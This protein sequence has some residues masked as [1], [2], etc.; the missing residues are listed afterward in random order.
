MKP[1]KL[2]QIIALCRLNGV[3]HFKHADFEIAFGE[4]VSSNIVSLG[5]KDPTIKPVP[6]TEMVIP[7]QSTEVA[8]LLKLSDMDLVDKLF[9]DYTQSGAV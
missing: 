4:P 5:V 8:N 7:H 2:E 9:P 3:T 1:E 6:P